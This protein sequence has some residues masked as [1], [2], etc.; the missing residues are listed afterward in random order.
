MDKLKQDALNFF[1]LHIYQFDI[2]LAGIMRPDFRKYINEVKAYYSLA[3][4]AIES[5]ESEDTKYV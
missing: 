4:D 1:K 3:I 2:M 5:K